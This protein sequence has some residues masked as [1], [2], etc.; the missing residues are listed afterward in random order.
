MSGLDN[1]QKVTDESSLRAEEIHHEHHG[2]RAHLTDEEAAKAAKGASPTTTSE[3]A[4]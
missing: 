1:S 2:E 4:Q 3:P